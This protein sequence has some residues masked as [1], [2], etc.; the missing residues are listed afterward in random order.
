MRVVIDTND[1]HFN[2]LK[3]LEFPIINVVNEDEFKDVCQ[4]KWAV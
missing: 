1:R 3:T 2:H 4:D